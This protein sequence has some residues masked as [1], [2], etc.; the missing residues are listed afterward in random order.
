MVD[1]LQKRQVII[2]ITDSVHLPD[3]KG[4]A[5]NL[6]PAPFGTSP[7]H[8]IDMGHVQESSDLF[9]IQSIDLRRGFRGGF[10]VRSCDGNPVDMGILQLIE[11]ID[12][13]LEIRRV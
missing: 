10:F 5:D 6:D 11:G 4:F 9:P 13:C 7:G 2:G 8:Y 1:A 3:G 12:V